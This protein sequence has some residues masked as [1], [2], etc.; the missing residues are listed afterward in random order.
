MRCF[1]DRDVRLRP[2][3]RRRLRAYIEW[4][5]CT[6]PG[7]VGFRKHAE[8]FTQ[9]ERSLFGQFV[10]SVAGA[11]GIVSG[12]EIKA[13]T[14][15]YR[16]IGLNPTHVHRDCHALA[17]AF[18]SQY[19]PVTIR[20]PKAADKGFAIP[21]RR[22]GASEIL[23][24]DMEAVREK[25]RDTNRVATMLG[26]LFADEEQTIEARLGTTGVGDGKLDR[27]HSKLVRQLVNHKAISRR[28]FVELAEQMGLLPEG[29]LVH[30]FASS[31]ASIPSGVG[32]DK[33]T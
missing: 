32:P 18:P 4:L 29:A 19:E 8:K 10:V 3:E 22:H 17:A 13:L 11:D 1:V 23:Q 26:S 9:A 27:P 16:Q 20:P 14:R 6:R 33:S 12:A 31:P 7:L 15:V 24:L 2:V 21:V 25:L 30:H 28:E 5:I